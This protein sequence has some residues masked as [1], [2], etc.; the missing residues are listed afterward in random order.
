MSCK[1]H[2]RSSATPLLSMLIKRARLIAWWQEV[3]KQPKNIFNKDELAAILRFGAEDLFKED[4]GGNS[5][6][7]AL[8]QQVRSEVPHVLYK[9]FTY[10]RSSTA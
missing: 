10:P 7:E 2:I 6:E 4:E 5:R 1:L 3:N 8:D 9:Q